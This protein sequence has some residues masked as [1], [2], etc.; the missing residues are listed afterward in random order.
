MKGSDC[1]KNVRK[2]LFLLGLFFFILMSTSGIYALTNQETDGTLSTGIVD[3]SIDNYTLNENNEEIPYSETTSVVY[4][5]DKISLIP[6]INNLGES[7]FVRVK[8]NYID[9]STNFLDYTTGFSNSL[10][11]YG[12]YY[13]YTDVLDNA[14]NIKI[15]DAIKIPDDITTTDNERK[16]KLEIIAEAI[17]SKNF[18]P[19]YSLSDPWKGITPSENTKSSYDIDTETGKLKI[20]ILYEDNTIN[21]ISVNKDF[22]KQMYNVMPGDNFVDYAELKNTSKNSNKYYLKI[23]TD[24]KK[25]EEINLLNNI[26]LTITNKNGQIIYNGNLLSSEKFLLGE[27]ATND[28]DKFEF[29]IEVPSELENEFTLLNPK[30]YFVFSSESEE[31]T[32]KVPSNPKTGDKIDLALTIFLFSSICLVIIIILAYIE[33][34]KQ[35]C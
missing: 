26:H 4:P 18:V 28:Y 8:I 30:L 35:E 11:K 12:D 1:I 6:K 29:K 24:D 23:L 10:T 21:D 22:F 9:T 33:K 25:E 15:F 7:C 16:I 31:D 34:K 14:S 19:D 2:K 27:Y 13:Y 20:N 17:Q 32:N 5:G 3:I